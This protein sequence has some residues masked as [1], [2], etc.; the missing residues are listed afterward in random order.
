MNNSDHLTLSFLSTAISLETESDLLS[1]R[2]SVFFFVFVFDFVVNELCFWTRASSSLH[3]MRL[4]IMHFC[5]QYLPNTSDSDLFLS[6]SEQR[7]SFDIKIFEEERFY[8]FVSVGL[9]WFVMMI[10]YKKQVIVC[11]VIPMIEDFFRCR[12][13]VHHVLFCTLGPEGKKIY[14]TSIESYIDSPLALLV[15]PWCIYV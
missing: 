6:L 3:S 1:A 4:F 2:A 9:A 5:Y 10:V 11:E 14:H 8:L 12:V 13:V 15:S 7:F